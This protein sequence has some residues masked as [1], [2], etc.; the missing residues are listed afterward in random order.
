MAT[1]CDLFDL[2]YYRA[3]IALSELPGIGCRTS[4][5]LLQH[6]DDDP[7]RCLSMSVAEMQQ[8]RLPD[9]TVDA[10]RAYQSGCWP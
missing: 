10:I 4:L 2:S 3:W 5:K 1:K 9:K 6:F 7:F 8:L